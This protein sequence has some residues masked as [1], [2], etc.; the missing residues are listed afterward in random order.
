VSPFSLHFPVKS[1]P[2]FPKRKA[3]CYDCLEEEI[4]FEQTSD[5]ALAAEQAGDT[6]PVIQG[7]AY[8]FAANRRKSGAAFDWDGV[9][10]YVF[11]VSR[12]ADTRQAGTEKTFLR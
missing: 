6:I 7:P 4:L 8:I 9:A 3:D 1:V 11:V 12:S 5:Q 10:I 2:I